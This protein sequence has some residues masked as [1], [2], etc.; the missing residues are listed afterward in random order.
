MVIHHAR[1]SK[2]GVFG[3]FELALLTEANCPARRATKLAD[4]ARPVA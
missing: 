4:A 2:F 3:A 1:V